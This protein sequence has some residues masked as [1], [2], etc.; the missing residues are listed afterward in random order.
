M[1]MAA[2]GHRGWRRG[3]PGMAR[4]VRPSHGAAPKIDEDREDGKDPLGASGTH[5]WRKSARPATKAQFT[6]LYVR[7]I[8]AKRWGATLIPP[9]NPMSSLM[10]TTETGPARRRK[11][12]VLGSILTAVVV[13]AAG[14]ALVFAHGGGGWRHGG[15]DSD[16]MIEH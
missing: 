7:A 1:L 2:G 12:A 3:L 10:Q 14:S 16:E 11:R 6:K 5:G 13:L 4:Q 9:Q 8:C 15:M